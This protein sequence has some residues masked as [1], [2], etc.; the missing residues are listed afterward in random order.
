MEKIK[1]YNN[2]PTLCKE[3]KN[4][5]NYEKRHNKFCSRSC[6][7]SFNNRGIQRHGKP[8]VM[9]LNCEKNTRNAKYC[10]NKCQKVHEWNLKKITIIEG[11]CRSAPSLKRFLLEEEGHK[12]WKCGIRE[13]NGHPAPL[14]LEHI[15]GNSDNNNLQNLEI[16]CCNCHAQTPTYKAKNKGNGRFHRRKRY[17]EGKSY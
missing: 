16:L 11:K 14:E 15:D 1:N 10:S 9:C 17:I 2:S 8:P 5:I 4:P 6:A 7:A 12:C 3:C 13:W